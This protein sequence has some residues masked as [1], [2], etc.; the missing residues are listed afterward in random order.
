MEITKPNYTD[1][2]LIIFKRSEVRAYMVATFVTTEDNPYDYFKEFDEW[3]A[4]DISHGYDVIGQPYNTLSYV[5][6]VAQVDE[7]M[8]EEEY[9]QAVNEAVDEILRLNLTGNYKKVID[10]RV[11]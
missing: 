5:A 2:T 11:A 10:K 8:T 6:R 1:G 3:Y 4:F 7:S 9:T